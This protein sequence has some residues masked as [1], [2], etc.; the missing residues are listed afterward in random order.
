MPT[1]HDLLTGD[2]FGLITPPR[3]ELPLAAVDGRTIALKILRQ[4]IS[5]LHFSRPDRGRPIKYQ[6][7]LENIHLEQPA[8]QDLA[9]PSIVFRPGNG[10]YDLIG[11]G[12]YINESTLDRYAPGTA[13]QDQSE[14]IETIT[15]EC[16]AETGAQR[17]SIVAGLE[18]ALVPI[19]QYYG[20]R[21]RMPDY[22]D[23]MVVFAL[24]A[25]SRPDD[26]EAAKNRRWAVLQVEMRFNVVALVNVQT[27]KPVLTAEVNDA[28]IVTYAPPFDE[29]AGA[30]DQYGEAGWGEEPF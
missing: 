29:E 8:Q 19:E 10:Q 21:F 28:T 22:F 18:Q 25:G 9:F 20:L 24:N 16:W 15:L 14:W 26:A 2:P 23:Q 30:T 13:V 1:A 27:M 6:I 5:E 4:Y 7:P 3:P 12:A 11:M 17:A